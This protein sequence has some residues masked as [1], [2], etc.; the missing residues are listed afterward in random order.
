MNVYCIVK[1]ILRILGWESDGDYYTQGTYGSSWKKG[2]M[3]FNISFELEVD[4]DEQE[5]REQV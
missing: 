3:R 5:E 2:S 4:N 1:R